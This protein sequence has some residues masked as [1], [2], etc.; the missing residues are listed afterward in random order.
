MPV[1][2]ETECSCGAI[3][4]RETFLTVG[5]A[6]YAMKM[7]SK[8]CDGDAQCATCASESAHEIYLDEMAATRRV[9]M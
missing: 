6:A 5:E 9:V 3:I 4:L 1:Y 7:L 8:D 2:V